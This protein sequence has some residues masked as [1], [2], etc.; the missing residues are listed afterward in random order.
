MNNPTKVP[1]DKLAVIHDAVEI[2][3]MNMIITFVF[4]FVALG[5]YLFTKGNVSSL[6]FIFMILQLGM[7]MYI[8]GDKWA[9]IQ[10]S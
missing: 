5:I 9:S 3:L 8:L 10:R 1:Y 4:A 7:N 6:V 2:I